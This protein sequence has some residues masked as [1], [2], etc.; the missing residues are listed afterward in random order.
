MKSGGI[1][2]A[3]R[4]QARR[5]PPQAFHGGED[6]CGNR[7]TVSSFRAHR[8]RRSWLYPLAK[9]AFVDQPAKPHATCVR[10]HRPPA[11]EGVPAAPDKASETRRS[12][13]AR[14]LR[15]DRADDDRWKPKSL[16]FVFPF[17]HLDET[18]LLTRRFVFPLNFHEGKGSGRF[19]A[20]ARTQGAEGLA[21]RPI[22]KR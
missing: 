11:A 13:E 2:P 4:A 10:L 16:S 6:G 3:H 8:Y 1:L 14:R 20:A 19:G 5:K 7:S 12:V 15:C 22:V 18:N 17:D 9:P 21:Y